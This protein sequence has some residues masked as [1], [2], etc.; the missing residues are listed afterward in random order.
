MSEFIKVDENYRKWIEDVS[1][2]FKQSQIK[3]AMKVNEEMLRFYWTLGRD[4][5]QLKSLY[6]W[7]DNMYARIGKDLRELLPD[8]KS[9]S[10]RNLRYMN[11]FYNFYN[12]VTILPQVGAK[13]DGAE[14]TTRVSAE[15]SEDV[16]FLIP[17]GHHKLIIDKCKGNHKRA[18]FFV[19]KTIENN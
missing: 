18:L 8:I 12:N 1:S 6:P 5:E 16:I 19:N 7:G 3:A 15:L 14:S 2:R 13:L 11:S 4:I 9:F 10:S 17:W